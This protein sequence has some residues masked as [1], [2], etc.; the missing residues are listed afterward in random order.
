MMSFLVMA[1][2]W[3]AVFLKREELVGV[4]SVGEGEPGSGALTRL[5]GV[6]AAMRIGRQ[7]LGPLARA[8]GR[9]GREGSRALAA[10]GGSFAGSGADRRAATGKL[11]RAQL[12]RAAKRRLDDRYRQAQRTVGVQEDRREELARAEGARAELAAKSEGLRAAAGSAPPG[13]ARR[14]AKAALVAHERRLE[15]AERGVANAR[16]RVRGG[17]AEAAGSAAFIAAAETRRTQGGG[18]WGGRELA[19][20]RE[21]IRREVDEPVSSRAHAW[22]VGMAPERYE[23]LRGAER[24]RAHREVEAGLRSDR[25]AFGAIPERPAGL[26]KRSESRRYRQ[27]LR[28]REGFAA[29]RAVHA[30]G[31]ELRRARRRSKRSTRRAL[32]RRGLSR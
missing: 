32:P 4:L 31:R 13:P 15:A 8:G 18:R 1:A 16:E 23:A 26:P 14:R 5:L 29:D 12:D 30:G 3:W 27:V 22:R 25:A 11:A 19:R 10:A 24:E 9:G 21:A 7:L 20:S 17:E 28:E 6:Y 2:L